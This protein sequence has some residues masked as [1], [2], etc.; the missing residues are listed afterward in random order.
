MPPNLAASQDVNLSQGTSADPFSHSHTS[1]AFFRVPFAAWGRRKWLRFSLSVVT[2]LLVALATYA[3]YAVF[4]AVYHS[5]V[6]EPATAS[7]PAADVMRGVNLGGWLVLETWVT[8]S[9]FYPFL[10]VGGECPADRPPVIDERSF[11]DRLGPD[12]ARRR[13][14]AFRDEWVTEATFA[15]IARAGLNTVRIPFGYWV[16]G[17]TDLCPS[18][19]SI[20][21]L[22]NAVQWAAAHGLQVILDLHGLPY[23]QNGMDHS[24]TSTHPP[25]AHAQPL[26]GQPPLDGTAWLTAAHLNTTR[27]VLKRVAVRYANEAAVVRIGMV[28]EPMLMD[29]AWCDTNC[30]MPLDDLVGY[31]N[32]TWAQVSDALAAATAPLPS[33]KRPVLDIGLGGDP[34]KWAAMAPLPDTNSGRPGRP[35]LRDGVMDAHVYQAWAP[36]G[37]R[38]IPQV[39]HLR[40]A[41][42]DAANSLAAWR[43]GVLPVMVGE[44]ST[45]LTD[46]E[47]WLNG[48][49]LG[50]GALGTHVQAAC[51]RVPCP[52]TFNNLTEGA[53]LTGGPDKDGT[54]PMGLLPKD[55]APIGPLEGEEFYKL[56]TEYMVGSYETSAGWTYWNFKNEIR[57]P[58][59]SFFDARNRSWFAANLSLDAY[60]P[61][62]PNCAAADSLFGDLYATFAVWVGSVLAAVGCLV[63]LCC[64]TSRARR[65]RRACARCCG[66][67]CGR[68][69]RKA[70]DAAAGAAPLLE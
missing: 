47:P 34:K 21:H 7:A 12:E 60:A 42:C 45:A 38:L 30:P 26:W 36:W 63:A 55:G 40:L 57:D 29:R 18:V 20:H 14:D 70:V 23:T 11:C 46:C 58:R 35:G 10:C 68:K 24:G 65:M 48:L 16:F 22:D 8:P 19:S 54:C 33:T 51:S 39:V 9:L 52:T 62:R 61:R 27:A 1:F 53:W 50:S 66:R 25:F 31:Y 32:E 49:G 6:F 44:W 56:L 13:L 17:D 67:R 59:W 3:T 28:N 15:D 43:D 37:I 41:A 64:M 5:P 2:I 4:Y 69:R